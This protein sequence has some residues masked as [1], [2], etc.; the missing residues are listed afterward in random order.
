MSEI[1]VSRLSV[2]D[3]HVINFRDVMASFEKNWFF[4]TDQRTTLKGN[5]K[6]KMIYRQEI[7]CISSL[8]DMLQKDI[9][10][11]QHVAEKFEE[12]DKKLQ[13]SYTTLN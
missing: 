13:Q 1:I 2:V 8:M 7:N 12:M 4:D 6:I 9:A 5:E 11:I 3:E 10:N